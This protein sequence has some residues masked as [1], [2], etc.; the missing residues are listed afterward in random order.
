MTTQQHEELLRLRRSCFDKSHVECEREVLGVDHAFAGAVVARQWNLPSEI[1]HAIGHHHSE[2]DWAQ[3][4]TNGVIIANQLAQE[5]YSA[6]FSHTDSENIAEAMLAL[7]LT[8]PAY[9]EILQANCS[10]TDALISVI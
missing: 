3:N 1:V 2:V 5:R 4:L 9:N 8:D 6:E 7:G 10:K